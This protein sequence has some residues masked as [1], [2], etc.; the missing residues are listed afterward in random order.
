MRHSDSQ[1]KW[2]CQITGTLP[3]NGVFTCSIDD[4]H[5]SDLKIAELLSKNCL[6]GTFFIPIKNREGLPVLSK[7]QIRDIGRQF[8]IGSHTYDHCYLRNVGVEEAFYQIT[9]GKKL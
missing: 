5:P 8:E 2:R 7:S 3:M 4:G 1:E 9:E 6:N